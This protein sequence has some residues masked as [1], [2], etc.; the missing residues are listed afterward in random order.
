MKISK[1]L[2]RQSLYSVSQ[3]VLLPVQAGGYPSRGREGVE[4]GYSTQSR[5][6]GGRGDKEV[7]EAGPPYPDT[8][9]Q[10]WRPQELTP[11]S[12]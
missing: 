8:D 10:V 9:S 5:D 3:R 6:K 1:N 12:S 4:S 7:N 2:V 11:T